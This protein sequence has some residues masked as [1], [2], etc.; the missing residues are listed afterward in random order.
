MRSFITISSVTLGLL[1]GLSA[2]AAGTDIS[3]H[4]MKGRTADNRACE[5]EHSSIYTNIKGERLM[6]IA[7]FRLGGEDFKIVGKAPL[8]EQADGL[9]SGSGMANATLNKA[10]DFTMVGTTGDDGLLRSVNGQM[11]KVEVDKNGT[12]TPLGPS[13]DF[14]CT[15]L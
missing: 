5:I 13:V 7:F 2:N 3:L 12:K 6:L 4:V 8:F 14:A 9:L 11:Q 10:T 1:S 15:A